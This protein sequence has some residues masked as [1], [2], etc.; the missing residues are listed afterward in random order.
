MQWY[1]GMKEAI[2]SLEQQPNR[3]S[4]TREKHKLRQ[5]FY[6]HKPHIYRVSYRVLEKQRQVEVLHVR[7]GARR[8]FKRS[9]LV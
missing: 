2:L 1:L 9:D 4:L 6:G 5:L 7:Y 8:N 3:G